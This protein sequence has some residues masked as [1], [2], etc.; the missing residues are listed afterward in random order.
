ML[1]RR[2]TRSSRARAT[3]SPTIPACVNSL[4][5]LGQNPRGGIMTFTRG[6]DGVE[7]HFGEDGH[8]VRARTKDH[9]PAHEDALGRVAQLGLRLSTPDEWDYARGAGAPTLFRWGDGTPESGYPYD[10]LERPPP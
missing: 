9:A 5:K 1:G 10:H 2:S 4:R 8:V 6:G 7:V 3:S